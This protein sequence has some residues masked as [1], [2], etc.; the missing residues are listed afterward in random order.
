MNSGNSMKPS[1]SYLE[2]DESDMKMKILKGVTVMRLG[3]MVKNKI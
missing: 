1:S 2:E 3:M